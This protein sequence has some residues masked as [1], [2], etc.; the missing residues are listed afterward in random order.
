MVPRLV[1]RYNASVL[2][3]TMSTASCEYDSTDYRVLV[4]LLRFKPGGEKQWELGRRGAPLL[5]L[6]PHCTHS[7]LLGDTAAHRFDRVAFTL[8]REQKDVENAKNLQSLCVVD[9]GSSLAF[10]GVSVN[11]PASVSETRSP[12]DAVTGATVCELHSCPFIR[13]PEANPRSWNALYDEDSNN[14]EPLVAMNILEVPDPDAYA[15]YAAHFTDLP[16]KY[17]FKM[18]QCTK[19]P[20]RETRDDAYTMLVAAEFPNARAF[21]S[22]CSDPVIRDEA[23]PLREG[24]FAGGFR[25]IWL[26]CAHQGNLNNSE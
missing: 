12:L 1:L 17:G 22:C 26:R 3:R 6:V 7:V 4:E 19:V 24:L 11:F 9:D 21:S 15:Q 20:L 23:Y 25:H 13:D 18:L 16:A 14:D 2:R 10:D 8:F 5:D